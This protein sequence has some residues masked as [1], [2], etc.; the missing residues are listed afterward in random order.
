MEKKEV[1]FIEVARRVVEAAS[2][3]QASDI[4][5]LDAREVCS[6]TDYFVIC[7]GESDHQIEAIHNAVTAALKK[8]G[9]A[10]LHAEGSAASGWVLLDFGAVIVNIFSPSQRDYYQL[11]E[12]WSNAHPLVRMQ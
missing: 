4:I 9:S 2:D 5:L 7:S 3:K 8:E 10:L 12:L 1:V 11:D 6:F